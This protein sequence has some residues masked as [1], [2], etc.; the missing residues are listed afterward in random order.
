MIGR[1]L[2]R[3]IVAA[4]LLTVTVSAGVHAVATVFVLRLLW[5][6]HEADDLTRT[7]EAVRK[8][9]EVEC[10][11]AD[12]APPEAA[13]EA[14][15]ATL[16]PGDHAVL[17]SGPTVLAEAG[18]PPPGG[19]A[20]PV[21]GWVATRRELPDGGSVEI[22]RR[23][24]AA[25][26]LQRLAW[27]ALLV[28]TVPSFLVAVLV[29]RWAGRSVAGP[30][31]DLAGRLARI[32]H[33]RDYL[34][35]PL[36]QLPDEVAVLE[37]AFAGVV[38]RLAE[39][40]EREAEFARNAA[41]ELR[42]PL[43]RIRLRAERAA[44][45]SAQPCRAELEAVTAEVDRL[46]RLTDA[47]LVLARDETQ[48]VGE[49]ETVNLADL[50]RH[51]AAQEGRTVSTDAPDEVYVRGD[52][53][54]LRLAVTNLLDNAR[55]YAPPD[56]VPFARLGTEGDRVELTVETPGVVLSG[57]E[58]LRAFERFFRGA[59]AR[60]R[61]EGHGL[62]LSLARHIARVHGGDVFFDDGPSEGTLFRLRLPAWRGGR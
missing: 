7:V 45:L 4:T 18:T 38:G 28:A 52:E 29:G 53:N 58:R 24:D 59:A 26:P 16:G 47:L 23:H 50:V 55:K 60:E 36:E 57:E 9:W 33:P 6:R 31:E 39:A 43:T 61:A 56:L 13:R 37:S 1:A 19:G 10:A 35:V 20:G 2:S 3:R 25:P 21:A 44:A 40:L 46:S 54:L 30:V 32:R 15:L 5:R 14:L 62:G 11:E 51:A 49:G 42:T 22:H 48:G 27:A 41:H 12:H 17:R 8:A 34:S